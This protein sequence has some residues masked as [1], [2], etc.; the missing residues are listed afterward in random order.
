[1]ASRRR[2]TG[3]EL[4]ERQ[5]SW[6]SHIERAEARGEAL[7]HYA[8]R[9]GLSEHA[10]YEAK[11]RLREL[12]ALDSGVADRTSSPRFAQVVAK[13]APPA[14][15][16]SLRVRLPG[17]AELEWSEAP[18]GESLRELLRGLAG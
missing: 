8:Q 15:G 10:I 18:Q 7:K 11:R 1:M 13:A 6:L 16:V 4:T 9:K 17:G 2:S 3:R 14:I 5:Q 12:G